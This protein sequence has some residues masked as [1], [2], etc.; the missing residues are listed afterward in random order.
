MAPMAVWI[1]LQLTLQCLKQKISTNSTIMVAL[2][3]T[4]VIKGML[5]RIGMYHFC[6]KR[7]PQSK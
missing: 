5:L 1:Q 7:V 3:A 6:T 2:V 4:R